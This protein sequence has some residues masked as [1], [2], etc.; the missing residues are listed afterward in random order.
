MP[1]ALYESAAIELL[2]RIAECTP[3]NGYTYEVLQAV[4]ISPDPIDYGPGTVQLSL[5]SLD[6]VDESQEAT[7]LLDMLA[8][9]QVT[10]IVE[11]VSGV[12]NDAATAQAVRDLVHALDLDDG[13]DIWIYGRLVTIDHLDPSAGDHAG[14][15]LTLELHI[16][17]D[18]RSLDEGP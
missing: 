10:A 9:F 11:Q 8:R 1:N 15:A 2:E 17:S 4:R 16:R 14:A 18:V 5:E 7:G 13:A 3:A 12:A 6:R